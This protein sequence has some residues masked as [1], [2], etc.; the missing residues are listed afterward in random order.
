MVRLNILL[1]IILITGLVIGG[2]II[3]W[4]FLP[5]KSK[6]LIKRSDTHFPVVSGYNLD[7]QEIEL[8]RDFGAEL[9]LVIVP[10]Q[11]NQQL[12]VNTWIPFAQE[13]E[14]TIPGF[15]YYELPTIYNLPAVARGFINEGMRAGIQDQT[16]RERTITLYLDKES[17][18]SALGIT[19]EEKIHLFLVNREGNILWQTTGRYSVAKATGLEEVLDRYD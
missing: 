14:R 5:N 12:D 3:M 19:T 6:L 10:F 17:F 1:R 16:S 7:R 8:P 18:K 2:V 13:M 11:Q 15:M 4:R 9:N